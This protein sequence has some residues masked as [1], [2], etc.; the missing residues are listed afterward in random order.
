MVDTIFIEN[1]NHR[2]ERSAPSCWKRFPRITAGSRR[3]LIREW[4]SRSPHAAHQ[5]K[6]PCV[7][8]AARERP[9]RPSNP[10]FSNDCRPA[11]RAFDRDSD[12]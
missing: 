5:R 11:H 7:E 6:A 4:R 3:D 8:P 1:I 12:L 2:G 9:V 10:L